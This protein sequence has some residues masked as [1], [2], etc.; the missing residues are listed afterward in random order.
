[1]NVLVI[2]FDSKLQWS[3]QVANVVKKSAKALHVI[4]LIK[5]FFCFNELRS[6]IMSNFYSILAVVPSVARHFVFDKHINLIINSK[7]QLQTC[8]KPINLTYLLFFSLS[9][10]FA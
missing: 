7:S 9:L 1:M 4:R 10:A 5:P 8:E 6:L 2:T 3:Q